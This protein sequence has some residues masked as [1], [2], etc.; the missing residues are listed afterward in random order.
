[1]KNVVITIQIMK[2]FFL[3]CRKTTGEITSLTTLK[4]ASRHRQT[5]T[6]WQ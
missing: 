3:Q 2:I 6:Q 5:K 4:L 1:M